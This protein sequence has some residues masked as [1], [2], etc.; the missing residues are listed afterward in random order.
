MFSDA[1][2]RLIDK[3]VKAVDFVAGIK[4][5]AT[6]LAGVY[7]EDADK[8]GTALKLGERMA[9]LFPSLHFPK[10]NCGNGQNLSVVF[11]PDQTAPDDK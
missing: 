5:L 6:E 2:E 4:E 7:G 11:A 10:G 3:S 8:D 1:R 9:E